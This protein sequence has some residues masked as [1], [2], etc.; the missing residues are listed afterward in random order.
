[1]KLALI[2]AGAIVIAGAVYV[3]L[4]NTTSPGPRE[5]INLMRMSR[6]NG[7]ADSKAGPGS[8][9]RNGGWKTVPMPSWPA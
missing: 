4:A 6:A 3:F 1:M 2:V 7:G 5:H 8:M 9:P